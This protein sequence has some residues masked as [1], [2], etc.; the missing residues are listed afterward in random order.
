[1]R[2]PVVVRRLASCGLC[3]APTSSRC[4]PSTAPRLSVAPSSLA[5]P[6]ASSFNRSRD[7]RRRRHPTSLQ[8]VPTVAPETHDKRC[9]MR[10]VSCKECGEA[11]NAT[12]KH[13]G[14]QAGGARSCCWG[15]QKTNQKERN[16]ARAKNQNAMHRFS[17]LLFL[18]FF[19]V[20][21]FQNQFSTQRTFCIL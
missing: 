5:A 15:A 16:V 6:A 9:M 10:R 12:D 19:L 17:T 4:R 13:P 1:M 2:Q 3:D 8:V 14:R 18:P 20:L 7:G 11:I 21:F